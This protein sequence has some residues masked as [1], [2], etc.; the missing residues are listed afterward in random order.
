MTLSRR[1]EYPPLLRHPAAVFVVAALWGVMRFACGEVGD[2]ALIT[3]TYARNLVEG[4]GFVFNHGEIVYGTTAPLWG[5]FAAAGM[6]LGVT[7]WT[8]SLCWDVL[9]GGV[10]LWRLREILAAVDSV[11]L[12]PLVGGLIVLASADTLHPAGMETGLYNVFVFSALAALVCRRAPWQAMMWAGWA[13]AL[14]PDGIAI[15][16]VA[17]LYGLVRLWGERNWRPWV[18][19]AA[20]LAIPAAAAIA[21]LAYFGTLVP[22][23]VVA[24]AVVS[25]RAPVEYR[26]WY[27]LLK[28]IAWNHGLPNVPALLAVAGVGIWARD[29]VLR[30][31]TAFLAAYL[32]FFIAGGAPGF[33]WY[34]TPLALLACLYAVLG[35]MALV[36][37][38]AELRGYDSA[39]PGFSVPVWTFVA[40]AAAVLPQLPGMTT[41]DA[42]ALLSMSPDLSNRRYR[43][44]AEM[45]NRESTPPPRLATTEIGYLGYFFDGYVFDI[46]GLVTPESIEAIENGIAPIFIADS[47]WYIVPVQSL[48]PEWVDKEARGPADAAG[49]TLHSKW[50]WPGGWTYVFRR[51]VNTAAP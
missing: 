13:M 35:A 46:Y 32:A 49:Y 16:G 36:R 17:G 28:Q 1:F 27:I 2:D 38:I 45:L 19:T 24:K 11:E 48:D 39:S 21:V 43:E 41:L 4:A 25:D 30:P 9:F 44:I 10:V 6:K 7:P 33:P 40:V 12:F 14:R 42:R 22:Q 37:R 29:S 51:P 31:V 5:L 20:P 8:W 26:F 18:V 34:Y 23:S 50:D 15:L 3:F 47:E